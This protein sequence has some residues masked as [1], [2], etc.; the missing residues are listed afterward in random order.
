MEKSLKP[1]IA[2]EQVHD[3]FRKTACG[4]PSRR[5]ESCRGNGIAEHILAQTA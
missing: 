4:K 5:E 3:T 1:K 2:A